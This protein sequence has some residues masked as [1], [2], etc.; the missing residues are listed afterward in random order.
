MASTARICP[1]SRVRTVEPNIEEEKLPRYRVIARR[2]L[3]LR[4][5][6]GTE[7]DIVDVLRSGQVVTVAGMNGDWFQVDI[8]GDGLADGYCHSGFLA[9]LT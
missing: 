6:P 9:R 7:Y 8:E 5:G 1:Q 4:E 2:G 3:R